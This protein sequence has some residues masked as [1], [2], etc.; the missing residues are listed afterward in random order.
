MDC[1][2]FVSWLVLFLI[3]FI[4]FNY[5]ISKRSPKISSD[6]F[7]SVH[8]YLCVN[9]FGMSRQPCCLCFKNIAGGNHSFFEPSA[10]HSVDF[11][12]RFF[13]ILEDIT[14]FLP[15]YLECSLIDLQ[16]YFSRVSLKL[17]LCNTSFG[18]C[19]SGF[20]NNFLPSAI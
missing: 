3:N 9:L 2:L 15:F 12:F 14:S 18:F 13:H 20:I 6:R 11:L 5:T 17:V 19:R 8:I 7:P 4:T 10:L 1:D 16:L